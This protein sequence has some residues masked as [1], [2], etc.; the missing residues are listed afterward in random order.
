MPAHTVAL[1]PT[2]LAVSDV[3]GW[4]LGAASIVIAVFATGL[5]M[6][7]IRQLRRVQADIGRARDETANLRAQMLDALELHEV[8][9]ADEHLKGYV[10]HFST[11]YA[12]IK[13]PLQVRL[14]RRDLEAATQLVRMGAEGH[15]MIGADAF[16]HAET[17]A[18]ILLETTE[19]GDELWASSLVLAD[20]WEHAGA[21]LRQQ[22]EAI[23]DREVKIH[24][25]FVFDTL[26]EYENE[27]AQQQIQRQV[28]VGVDV[29]RLVEPRT[30]PRDLVVV[31]K[32]SPALRGPALISRDADE[33]RGLRKGRLRAGW[34]KD[35]QQQASAE[36][37]RTG[38]GVLSWRE[39]YAMEWRVGSDGRIDHID[40][41]SANEL[42][43]EMVKRTWWALQGIFSEPGATSADDDR[44]GR[45]R[46]ESG[47]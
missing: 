7:H 35:S 47:S 33:R 24:R 30:A 18:S 43:A 26:A 23:E 8:V 34:R 22:Q 9:I 12:R 40:L 17:L 41:W 1:M 32:R 21:Y 46:A 25:I 15:I 19:P 14:A 31:R 27:H 45:A 13:D 3:V 29:R 28:N 44:P 20:Y 2:V 5:A 11:E 4:A 16:S 6:R 39:A 36:G 37:G 42:Q 38:E 10:K